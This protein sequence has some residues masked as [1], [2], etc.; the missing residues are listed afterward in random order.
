M[1]IGSHKLDSEESHKRWRADAKVNGIQKKMN[2]EEYDRE[3]VE[4]KRH[5]GLLME[6]LQ[7]R[8]EDQYSGFKLRRKVRWPI[9]QQK[10]R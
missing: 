5:L 4:T 1:T 2:E 6:L 3:L 7:K 8:D 9:L 10:Q